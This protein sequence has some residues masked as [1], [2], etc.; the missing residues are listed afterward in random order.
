VYKLT[1]E[2][3]HKQSGK[4]ETLK[5]ERPFA[6]WF[7][8]AGRFVAAPF[9]RVLARGVEVI[10]MADP[11]RAKEEEETTEGAAATTT[12]ATA[13]TPEML[14]MLAKATAA[15][16][17]AGETSGVEDATATGTSVKKGGKRRKA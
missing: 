2:I 14:E 9:Q 17:S 6:E 8:E 10:G 7:D 11:K 5:I 3:S 16:S 4:K 12:T 13:Y 15:G 1:V